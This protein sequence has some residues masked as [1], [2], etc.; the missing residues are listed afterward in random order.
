MLEL[1]AFIGIMVV[2]AG[3]RF[4]HLST[5]PLGFHGDEAVAGL[6]AQRILREGY[7][8]PYNELA[9]G[10]PTGPMYGMALFIR[11]FGHT[12]WAVR[13]YAAL[14]GLLTVALFYCFLRRHGG[15]R[16]AVLG[17]FL[18][19]VLNWHVHFSRI[20]FPLINWPFFVVLAAFA[21]MEALQR[22]SSLWWA[23]AGA[24]AGLGIY[25]YN[26][27]PLFLLALIIFIAGQLAADKTSPMAARAKMGALFLSGLFVVAL[28]MLL[29]VLNPANNYFGHTQIISIFNTNDWT[30][31]SGLGAKLGFLV[32]RYFGWWSR[33]SLTPEMD[34]GDATGATILV[35]PLLV[36]LAFAGLA[37]G[38]WRRRPLL[39]LSALVIAIAPLGYVVTTGGV[40]RRTFAM[41]PF[42]VLAVAYCLNEILQWAGARQK[43]RAKEYI[44]GGVCLLLGWQNLNLY[45][46]QF[47][48][49]PRQ[50]WEYAEEFTSA[51]KYMKTLPP[52]SY[53][54]FASDRWTL[55]Y[56][57]RQFLAPEIQGEDRSREFSPSHTADFHIDLKRGKPVFVLV[58]TYKNSLPDVWRLYRGG[59]MVRGAPIT[60]DP[61]HTPSFIAYIPPTG[62]VKSSAPPP[63]PF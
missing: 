36:L 21:V 57:P 40:A 32:R 45:F 20:G 15:L 18:L 6:V 63:P 49:S 5:L 26:A 55:N 31:L 60:G 48:N 12:I 43:L 2:A 9:L 11:L 13:S 7:I 53:A 19:A 51:L 34:I 41:A 30:S 27:H 44:I 42:L 52:G 23:I 56:E 8:G 50:A 46:V 62:P 58:G 14:E 38:I 28:P 29:F 4:Y 47:A 17:S 3:V 54:Y 22:R 37:W 33:V 16:M 39:V 24:A 35:P 1:V 25:S 59:T 10:Q 61:A